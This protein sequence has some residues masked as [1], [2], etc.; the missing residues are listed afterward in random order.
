MVGGWAIGELE[1]Y[2]RGRRVKGGQ[3]LQRAVELVCCHF[4]WVGVVRVEL[5][6]RARYISVYGWVMFATV[7]KRIYE[8]QSYMTRAR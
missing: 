1:G 2:G 8:I 4:G 5:L 6:T 7:G 3:G